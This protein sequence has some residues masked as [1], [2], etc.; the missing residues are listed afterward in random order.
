LRIWR[1]R[2][3]FPS[4]PLDPLYYKVR[5]SRRALFHECLCIMPRQQSLIT[6][7]KLGSQDSGFLCLDRWSLRDE[8]PPHYETRQSGDFRW[9]SESSYVV[10][11]HTSSSTS[12]HVLGK[13][14]REV[15]QLQD[16]LDAGV[17]S[18]ELPHM[19]FVQRY[20][21]HP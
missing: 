16:A 11:E 14:P 1:T 20:S 19:K 15:Y 10:S 9:G 12:S 4:A 13:S 18:H 21:L 2:W 8:R 5:N 7:E 3:T 6:L 17:I